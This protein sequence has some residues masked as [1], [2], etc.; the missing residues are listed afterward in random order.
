[1]ASKNAKDPVHSPHLHSPT[2]PFLHRLAR[3]GESVLRPKISLESSTLAG[4]GPDGRN[5]ASSGQPV[6]VTSGR[7]QY[8]DARGGH[9]GARPRRRSP[10]AP[11]W[12]ATTRS[13]SWAAAGTRRPRSSGSLVAEL[14]VAELPGFLAPVAPGHRGLV[15]SY[16]LDGARGAGLPRPH[17]PVRGP[18]AGTGRAP[19][20]GRGRGRRAGR[21]A[22]QRQRRPAR[23]TG[24]PG[25]G[26]LLSDHLNLTFVSPLA[27][28]HF[29]D[30]TDAWSPRLRAARRAPPTRPSSRRVY[31]SC[32]GRRCRPSPRPRCCAR[33]GR[34]W[35]GCRRS[36]RRSRR[37][38]PAS[39]CSGSRR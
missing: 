21:R 37:A 5:V 9:G 17:P 2:R 19:G 16:D 30:L 28:P 35:S 1:M 23:R 13:W 10:G 14:P 26:A 36:S 4:V 6:D 32:A 3:G 29:V 24:R 25:T 15:R 8:G 39:S 27:G 34:T 22:H 12:P 33:W 7:G 11:A 18:R 38:P 20:A 31:A